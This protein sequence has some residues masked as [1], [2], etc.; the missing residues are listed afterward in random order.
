MQRAMTVM[1]TMTASTRST[2]QRT[3]RMASST[4]RTFSPGSA[5]AMALWISAQSSVNTT[6]IRVNNSP[7][8]PSFP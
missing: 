5:L 6:L 2:P 7:I 8:R 4:E 1:A 3:G